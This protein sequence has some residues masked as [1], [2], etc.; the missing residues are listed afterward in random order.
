MLCSLEYLH[1]YEWIAPHCKVLQVTSPNVK[2]VYKWE[3]KYETLY[4]KT[5]LDNVSLLNASTN[6]SNK[7]VTVFITLHHLISSNLIV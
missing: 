5:L 3:R 6:M 1:E 4:I 7:S 2:H